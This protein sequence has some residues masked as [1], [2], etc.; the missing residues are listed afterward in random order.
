MAN[1]SQCK[2]CGGE[3]AVARKATNQRYCG[4]DCRDAFWG[5]ERSKC[6]TRG[7]WAE[8]RYGPV[9]KKNLT[10]VERAWLAAI[11]DGEGTIGIYRSRHVRNR[12]GWKY[13]AAVSF[14]NTN[15]RLILRFRELTD[16]WA[17]VAKK[18]N[19]G[20]PNAKPI[21][22]LQIKR[23]AVPEFLGQIREY[24]VAKEQQA[25]LVLAFCR[26]LDESPMRTSKDHT[27][28]DRFYEETK[29]LNARGV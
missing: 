29:R 10:E 28:F 7:E 1:S 2:Q 24:L 16:C 4:K 21:F 20:N 19:G 17:T 27:V 18:V 23:R 25:D 5:E 12:S 6:V 8:E 13:Q 14:C 9:E 15:E 3:I 22:S 11:I 26:S